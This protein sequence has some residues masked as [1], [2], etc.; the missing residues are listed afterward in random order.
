MGDR[1]FPSWTKAVVWTLS[2]L[3]VPAKVLRVLEEKRIRAFAVTRTNPLHDVRYRRGLT[4]KDLEEAIKAREF[5]E[6]L[7]YRLNGLADPQ[8]RRSATVRRTSH[9]WPLTFLTN[10]AVGRAA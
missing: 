2:P 5:R 8:C 6:D 7:Y 3:G 10:S 4:S 9:S 1:F